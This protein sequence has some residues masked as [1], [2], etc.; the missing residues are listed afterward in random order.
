MNTEKAVFA[1]LLSFIP[2][3]EFDKCVARYNGN[4]RVKSIHLLGT[5]YRHVLCTIDIPGKLPGY[6]NLLTSHAK[7]TVPHRL[8]KQNF[9]EHHR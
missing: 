7:Q 9:K 8:K 5:V 6:L 2:R 1:Q 3:Y 4:Y